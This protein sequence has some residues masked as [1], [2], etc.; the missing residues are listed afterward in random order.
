MDEP[1]SNLD[2][3]LRQ[4]MRTELRQLQQRLGTHGG[5]RDA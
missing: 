1:L 3:Q 4:E 5:L 2:A